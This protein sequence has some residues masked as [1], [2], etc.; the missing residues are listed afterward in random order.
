MVL[1]HAFWRRLGSDPRL[2]GAF[3]SVNGVD[4][5]VVGVAPEGFTGVT[6]DGPDL[7]LS[8][9]SLPTVSSG[10]AK[11]E[12]WFH[13]VGR[14]KPGLDRSVART[15]LQSLFPDFTP[16]WIKDRSSLNPSFDL[17]PPGRWE[18]SGDDERDRQ[19][20][21]VFSLVLITASL[22]IL[23]IACLNL[24][25]ML[26]V[27]GAARSSEIT[28]RMALGG[29]RGR[30][31]RQL[32]IESALLAVL[33]GVLGTLLAVH[34]LRILT[35][36]MATLPNRSG[37][38]LQL[39]LNVRVLMA[40]LALCLTTALLFGMRPAL[41]LSKRD[42]ADVLKGGAGRVL[43]SLG[44][45]RA[46]LSLMVQ[47]ALAVA[48]VLSATLLTR[49]AL[50][51]ASPDPR[52]P[53]GDKLVVEIDPKAGGYDRIQG[54]RACEALAD[55]LASLP[56]VKA[57]GTSGGVFFGGGG[58]YSMGEYRPGAAESGPGRPLAREAALV[59]VGR[60]YFLAMQIP[61]LQGRLFDPLDSA[62]DAEKVAII[63]ESL[64]RRLRPDGNALG[65]L[66]RWGVF[67]KLVSDPYRVVGIVA[68]L[69]GIEFREA[70][71]QM[72]TPA[73]PNDLASCLYLHV[74]RT[75]SAGLLRQRVLERVHQLDSRLP[76]LSAATLAQK[77]KDNSS[78][79]LAEFGARLGLVSA[80][81]ALF[82]AAL[83]IYA[84]KGHMVVSR[85]SE[86]GIRMALGATHGSV[87]AMVLREGLALTTAGLIIGLALGL[88]A[89]KVAAHLLFRIGPIDPVS[90]AVTLALLGAASLLAGYLPAR[91][92]AKVDPMV[93]LRQE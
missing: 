65:C 33:G 47:T 11:V 76:I 71:G 55:H 88:A 56:Q 48:L 37:D 83:G 77:R 12:P 18:I 60:D 93:A 52:F 24:A 40:T 53:L 74:E 29:G 63:D 31:V 7:W 15:Q 21:V 34:G 78:V 14:L 91:R 45:R 67:T 3:V 89:A 86:I 35:A 46:G 5:Q 92:A 62:P 19:V 25:N 43:G 32:L 66:I 49:S 61:L 57:V 39:G 87:M 2:V 20:H 44:R 82:L 6:H 80:V 41:L 54:I 72:Y 79:W 38:S 69:P 9:A 4:C 10:W 1:A 64:A 58:H 81:A 84:I 70:R 42:L 50:R 23:G 30:I 27:Q 90:I 59:G 17:R 75:R 16:E 22:L 36:W 85:T 8:L 73:G 68:H 26:I 28:V 51:M 13:I